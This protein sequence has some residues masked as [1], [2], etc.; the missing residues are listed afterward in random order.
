[1]ASD[2]AAASALEPPSGLRSAAPPAL[3]QREGVGSQRHPSEQCLSAQVP[4]GCLNRAEATQPSVR[5]AAVTYPAAE[6]V[7]PQ[8]S[9]GRGAWPSGGLDA[10]VT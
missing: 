10:R 1:M 3:I 4:F 5:V 2:P 8:P 7:G 9:Y 6:G